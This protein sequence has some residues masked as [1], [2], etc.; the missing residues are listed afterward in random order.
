MLKADAVIGKTYVVKVSGKLTAVRLV[1]ES[2]YGGWYGVNTATNREVR[3]RTAG[4]LR[5]ELI[6]MNAPYQEVMIGV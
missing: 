1:R 5:R 3:V 6:P 4:R 2:P